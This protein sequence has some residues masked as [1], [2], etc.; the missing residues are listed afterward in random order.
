VTA[1]AT[2]DEDDRKLAA[3]M[4]S[5]LQSELVRRLRDPGIFQ[6]VVNLREAEFKPEADK[7]LR[8]EGMITRP[9]REPPEPSSRPTAPAVRERRQIC[10][11]WRSR[12][13]APSWS[14]PTDGLHASGSSGAARAID[15]KSVG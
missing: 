4:S 7:A 12:Q 3:G 15:R 10:G 2:K 6:R 1:P 8:P 13:A 14:R 11:L 5:Y 9:G